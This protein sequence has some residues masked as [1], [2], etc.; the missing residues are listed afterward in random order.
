VSLGGLT[1]AA[2]AAAN[3]DAM[4]TDLQRNGERVIREAQAN[5]KSLEIQSLEIQGAVV[6]TRLVKARG[7]DVG[8]VILG[9]AEEEHANL[10]VIGTHGRY[11]FDRLLLG[12]VAERVAHHAEAPVML[13][14]A[15]TAKQSDVASVTAPHEAVERTAW[16][17]PGVTPLKNESRIKS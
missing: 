11:G 2:H 6:K 14:R 7:Q 1:G 16:N 9:I 17:A 3:W 4:Y 13:V 5:T 12:S 10:I 8:T 15:I